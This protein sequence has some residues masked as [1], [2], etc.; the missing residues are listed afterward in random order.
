MKV[1]IEEKPLEKLENEI[2]EYIINTPNN[3]NPNVVRTMVSAAGENIS[4]GSNGKPVYFKVYGES[5]ASI[6][7]M[8]GSLAYIDEVVSACLDGTLAFLSQK[9]YGGQQYAGIKLPND[10]GSY[11]LDRIAGFEISG[12]NL[13][14]FNG[15]DTNF[16]VQGTGIG[17]QAQEIAADYFANL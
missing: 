6:Y 10:G 17:R 4:L 11:A 13:L 2:V 5:D 16:A 3:A 9:Y 8:D 14:W 15:A 1:T 7:H 12:E